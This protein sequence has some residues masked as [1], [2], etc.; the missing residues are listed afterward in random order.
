MSYLQFFKV[1]SL[2]TR[3]KYD[4]FTL[5]GLFLVIPNIDF[6]EQVVVQ[7]DRYSSC[8]NIFVDDDYMQI[9]RNKF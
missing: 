8:K 9:I 5:P 3:A 4:H 2:M 7:C 6:T 1:G